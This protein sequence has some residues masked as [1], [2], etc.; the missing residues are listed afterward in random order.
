MAM[1]T[2][3]EAQAHH[4]EFHLGE[5]FQPAGHIR[6]FRNR[7]GG[8]LAVVVPDLARAPKPRG[9]QRHTGW[10]ERP[11]LR[12][13]HGILVD[14]QDADLGAPP[15]TGRS[16]PSARSASLSPS[17]AGNRP[18]NAQRR[19]AQRLLVEGLILPHRPASRELTGLR[20]PDT[21]KAA[22]SA[23]STKTINQTRANVRIT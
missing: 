17:D 21:P 12:F 10:C 8:V 9:V 3:S 11:H 1:A 13:R 16:A 14:H 5:E 4:V 19:T 23:N 15:P 2:G 20:I 6:G 22:D 18:G 7:R